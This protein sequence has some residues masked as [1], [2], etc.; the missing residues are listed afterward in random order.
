M[1]NLVVFFEIPAVDF[2]QGGEILRS[3]LRSETLGRRMRNREDGL[4]PEENGKCPGAISWA[5]DFKPCENGTLVSLRVDDMETALAA[6][7]KLGGRVTC[8]KTKIEAEGLGY[9]STF[10]DLE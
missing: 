2:G 5:A 8:P 4:L 9:F 6:I 1:K 10:S 7:V 3:G